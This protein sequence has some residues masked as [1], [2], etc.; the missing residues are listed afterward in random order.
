MAGLEDVF[1]NGNLGTG[2]AVVVGAAVL[3]PIV[4]PL[5]RPVA[6]TMIKAG[7]VAFDQGRAAFAELSERAG[8][9]VA[10]VRHEME[11]AAREHPSGHTAAQQ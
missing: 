9:M 4:L 1:K 5:L 6:K 7:I 2:L 10:E 8:D 3:S 11:T